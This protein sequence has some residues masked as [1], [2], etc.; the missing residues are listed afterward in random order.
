MTMVNEL[1]AKEVKELTDGVVIK[2]E[3]R[4]VTIGG[5]GEP[6]PVAT[7]PPT[8][9]SIS[10]AVP[11]GATGAQQ[12]R[13]GTKSFASKAEADAYVIALEMNASSNQQLLGIQKEIQNIGKPADDPFVFGG[14][15]IEDMWFD[16]PRGAAEALYNKAKADIRRELDQETTG[17]NKVDEFWKSFYAK[18]PDL[19]SADK[20]VKLELSQVFEREPNLDN[21]KAQEKIAVAVRGQIAEILGS[22]G[23]TRTELPNKNQS[24]IGPSGADGSSKTSE[25]KVVTML[26]QIK[27][28]RRKRKTG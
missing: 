17:K 27:N 22:Q 7:E 16:D 3:P 13:V 18:N 4:T 10:T 15:K 5:P 1:S 23:V 21:D 14:K 11:P 19:K 2:A 20:L 25:T 12:F 9:D 8:A 6:A 24:V 28:D 26:D